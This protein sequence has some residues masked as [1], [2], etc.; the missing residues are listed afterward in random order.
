LFFVYIDLLPISLPNLNPGLIPNRKVDL[1]DGQYRFFRSNLPLLFLVSSIFLLL[2]FGIKKLFNYSIKPR[3]Y[4][5]LIFSIIFLIFINGS[6]I[7]F[8]FIIVII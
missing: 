6:C 3:L 7:I 5:Y 2:S 4:F 1:S 8:I